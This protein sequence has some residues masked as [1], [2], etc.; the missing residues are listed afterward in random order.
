MNKT[1]K[2]K[3]ELKIISKCFCSSPISNINADAPLK[4]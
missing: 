4:S 2:K 3:E 1:T